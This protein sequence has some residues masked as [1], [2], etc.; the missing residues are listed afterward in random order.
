MPT[1][2]LRFGRISV[3]M[4]SYA[5]GVCIF[6]L[7]TGKSASRFDLPELIS[8]HMHDGPEGVAKIRDPRA[9]ALGDADGGWPAEDAFE[10]AR[11]GSRCSDP[12]VKTRAKVQEVLPY[13]EIMLQRAEKRCARSGM[14]T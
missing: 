11:L 2:Y 12:A 10:F 7:L 8:D 14:H 3:K 9:L 4:D 6:E 1:E 5:F 13:L